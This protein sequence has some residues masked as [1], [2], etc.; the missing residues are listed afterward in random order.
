MGEWEGMGW[1]RKKTRQN[2][3][4][5]EEKRKIDSGWEGEKEIKDNINLL[6]F[7]RHSSNFQII[8]K[9]ILTNFTVQ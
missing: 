6:I 5:R 4:E 9:V 3:W 7:C 8:Y 1:E 2:K